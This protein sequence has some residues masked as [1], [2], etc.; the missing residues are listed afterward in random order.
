MSFYVFAPAMKNYMLIKIRIQTRQVVDRIGRV[1]TCTAET[2][3]SKSTRRCRYRRKCRVT[4]WNHYSTCG[5]LQLT[6]RVRAFAIGRQS[7]Q[8]SR[9]RCN[10]G[11][12]QTPSTQIRWHTKFIRNVWGKTSF[13]GWTKRD[14]KNIFWLILEWVTLFVSHA[15]LL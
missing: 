9:E 15:D 7:E 3:H 13:L 12:H 6:H 11:D 14:T 5:C 2:L 8:S 1:T 10:R 4:S